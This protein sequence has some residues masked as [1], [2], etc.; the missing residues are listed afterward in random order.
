MTV[1][2]GT[3]F[4][5]FIDPTTAVPAYHRRAGLPP[6][7]RPTTAV[8]ARTVAAPLG[9]NGAARRR[10][11]ELRADIAPVTDRT[12]FKPVATGE[13]TAEH[14]RLVVDRLGDGIILFDREG[15]CE[16]LNPEAVRIVGRPASEVIGK[17]I[18]QAVPDAMSQLVEGARDRL[19]AGEEVLLVRSYFAQGRWFEILGRPLGGSFLVHFH[20]ITERLQ[21]ESARR[22]SEERFR[23]L[24]NGVRDYS[25]V[26]LDPK[27][28]ITSWNPGAERISGYS[29]DEALGKPLSFLLP[30][31]LVERGEPA[32]RLEE[33]VRL[34]SLSTEHWGIRKD[35]SRRLVQSTYTSLLDDLGVP[36]GFAIVNHDVTEQR[37]MEESLRTNEERLRL[38]LDAGGVGT[39]EEIVGAE[40]LIV[41]SRFLA[42]CGLPPNR[43]PSIREWISIIHPEDRQH[44][45]RQRQQVLDA[46][47]EFEFEY[48]V[49][50]QA[51]CKTRWVECHGKA[52]E[53][54]DGSGHK[55]VIGVL[56]D[57]TRRHQADDFRKLA[58]GVIAHDLRSPLSAIKLAS[59]LI[60][61]EPL[62]PSTVHKV[63]VVVRTV[64]RMV[65]MGERLLLYSQAEFGGGL[66]LEKGFTDLEQIC[67]EVI[68]DFQMSHPDRQ[69]HFEAEGDCRGVWDRTRL[70]E[71]VSNLIGNAVKHGETREPV[72]VIA[73]DR[74]AEVALLVH[75]VGPPIP[76]ESIPALFEPFHYGQK[77]RA[78]GEDSF[79][80]GLYIVREVVAAHGGTIEVGSSAEAGTTFIVRLPR[81]TTAHPHPGHSAP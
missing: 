13:V 33:A 28:Q 79:G 74:G 30:P 4:T 68:G 22:Q 67:G 25:I 63:H 23:I 10:Q 37:R 48:R 47:G 14:L 3:S 40:R 43:E 24:V 65:K 31:E 44:A 11:N 59:Q 60:E 6:L 52:L 73:R 76:A 56:R 81:D 18:G 71:V 32:R 75:N 41:D 2:R 19:I 7:C 45:L 51:D 62:P 58:A 54:G 69:V 1:P 77:H 9:R 78:S 80:L 53:S 64:D 26:M 35:G 21:A 16:Y 61:R 70:G 38:A 34:G 49:T 36:S 55:R 66:P 57:T 46:G 72:Y 29:P 27:G 42:L 8:P 5:G 50:G 12:R 17:H 20:D 39:W 15:T